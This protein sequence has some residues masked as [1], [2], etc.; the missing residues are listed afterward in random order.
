MNKKELVK[1]CQSFV[2]ESNI[3][4]A[5][6]HFNN[7][8]TRFP[9]KADLINTAILLESD[10]NKLLENGRLGTKSDNQE[11]VEENNI[12]TRFLKT[13]DKFLEGEEQGKFTTSDDK[14]MSSTSNKHKK[15]SASFWFISIG[16]W[17]VYM[18]LEEFETKNLLF[19]LPL[20]LPL[21]ERYSSRNNKSS[22]PSSNFSLNP[23]FES[24][25]YGGLIGGAI[26][27]I[28]LG[29]LFY[30]ENGDSTYTIQ[31]DLLKGSLLLVPYCSIIGIV[32]GA[33]AQIGMII[34]RKFLNLNQYIS[35]LFGAILGSFVAGSIM[36]AW[37]GWFF[38]TFKTE[39]ISST[40]MIIGV[41]FGS[42][43][44]LLGILSYSYNGK[45]RYI[46]RALIISIIIAI[47]VAMLGHILFGSSLI[48]NALNGFDSSKKIIEHI[49]AGTIVG[50]FFGLLG[51]LIIGSTIMLYQYW[52]FYERQVDKK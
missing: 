32:F 23:S 1:T 28:I 41:I 31:S 22:S 33:L 6:K 42:I 15:L 8:I 21:F 48:N 29:I 19:L 49:K 25:I 7:E 37:G 16:T 52:K 51:G 47:F 35:T 12:E 9:E 34:F 20:S 45:Y 43:S 50:S 11:N 46:F 10:I 38:T 36:G 2:K 14:D 26:A 17:V 3:E 40:L 4:K 24:G 5:I 39:T 13:L 18:F 27:G 44:I 30:F